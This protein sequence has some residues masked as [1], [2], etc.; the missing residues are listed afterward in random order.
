MNL[1]VI[2][3][4][5]GKMPVKIYHEYLDSDRHF[6]FT[7]NNEVQ[8]WW[9]ADVIKI[10]YYYVSIGDIIMI[11]GTLSMI[12]ILGVNIYDKKK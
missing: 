11:L 12:I 7:D 8:N 5:G 4:N 9:L 10:G 6:A 1:A 2:T 3:F